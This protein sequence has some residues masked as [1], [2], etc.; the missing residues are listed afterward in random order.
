MA[1]EDQ[2]GLQSREL[3]DGADV[4]ARIAAKGTG[5]QA[6]TGLHLG[7]A[8]IREHIA[9]DGHSIGVTEVDDMARGMARCMDHAKASEDIS[10]VEH[11]VHGAGE[12]GDES[13]QT[14]DDEGR[15]L[16]GSSAFHRRNVIPMASKRH[17]ELPLQEPD[18]PLMIGVAMR[19]G[20]QIDCVAFELASEVAA[21]PP[22]GGVDQNPVGV[23]DV[24][25]IIDPS[26]EAPETR[27]DKFHG[28]DRGD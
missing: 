2:R 13:A 5:G 21:M 19:Q 25:T 10:I 22:S 17:A 27:C 18:R 14:I 16:H 1:E 15:W 12:S 28:V 9:D 6:Q 8:D 23:V 3:L 11:A 4:F 24:Q 7:E 26:A 20:N